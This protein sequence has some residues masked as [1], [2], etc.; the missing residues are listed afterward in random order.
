MANDVA[1]SMRWMTYICVVHLLLFCFI[2]MVS[3]LAC[4]MLLF[5]GIYMV[6]SL[7]CC[8]FSDVSVDG[9][10]LGL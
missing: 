1:S 2:S 7:A 3:R 4:Y 6:G 9:I 5:S 10:H 8:L